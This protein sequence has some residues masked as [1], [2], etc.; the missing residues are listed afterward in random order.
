MLKKEK[1]Q[2]STAENSP[3]FFTC[4]TIT[5]LNFPFHL[6]FFFFPF[7]IVTLCH[8][9]V[10]IFPQLGSLSLTNPFA[11]P[12]PHLSFPFSG[13]LLFV[14]STFFLQLPLPISAHCSSLENTLF[15]YL[16]KECLELWGL[17]A[18]LTECCH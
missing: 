11:L 7:L 2:H 4:S 13:N 18:G 12:L 16:L 8:P 10:P 14:F 17:M 5:F 9:T 3:P 1:K 6:Y 15:R